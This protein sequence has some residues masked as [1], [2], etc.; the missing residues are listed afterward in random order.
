MENIMWPFFSLF[1]ELACPKEEGLTMV[2]ENSLAMRGQ[3]AWL[4]SYA[5]NT[6]LISKINRTL[7]HNKAQVM[8]NCLCMRSSYSDNTAW[9][10]FYY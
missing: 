9:I 1:F 10:C 4:M 5:I 2:I 8:A 7:R 6:K 3:L